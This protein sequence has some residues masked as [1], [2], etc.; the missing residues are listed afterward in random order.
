MV[1]STLRRAIEVEERLRSRSRQ[2]EW[3]CDPSDRRLLA[4]I[5][6]CRQLGETRLL[7]LE[8]LL[9][10]YGGEGVI[11]PADHEPLRFW[12]SETDA[13]LLESIR[14]VSRFYARAAGDTAVGEIFGRFR[15]V[16]DSVARA[17]EAELSEPSALAG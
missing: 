10:Q 16:L 14:A 4:W 9:R 5:E 15:D 12:S 17:L 13:V 3:F 2:I 1:I 8:G 7:W 6:G 11:R